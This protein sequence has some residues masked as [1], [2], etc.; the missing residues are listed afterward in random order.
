MASPAVQTRSTTTANAATITVTLPASSADGDLIFIFLCA[1]TVSTTWSLNAGSSGWTELFDDN[2]EAGYYKQIGA[3]EANPVFDPSVTERTGASALRITGHENPATQVPEVSASPNTGTS[4]APDPSSVTPTGGSK[5]YLFIACAGHDDARSGFSA[6][7]TNYSN[8]NAFATGGGANGCTGAT[9]ERA[10]TASTDDPDAFATGRSEPWAARTVVIHPVG[11]ATP[12]TVSVG[13]TVVM[14]DNLG[15]GSGHSLTDDINFSDA[16]ALLFE[17]LKTLADAVVLGDKV[18]LGTGHVLNDQMSLADAIEFSFAAF[19]EAV[20]NDDLNNWAD[21]TKLLFTFDTSSTDSLILS[22]NVEKLF[23]YLQ[24][25]N[26]EINLLDATS[27]LYT[28]LVSKGD[29]LSISDA[30]EVLRGYFKSTGDDLN[31]WQDDTARILLAFIEAGPA[32]DLN[33]WQ[34]AIE[35]AALAFAGRTSGDDLNAWAEFIALRY[36]YRIPKGEQFSIADSLS[37]LLTHHLKAQE[38]MTLTDV[39]ELLYTYLLTVSDQMTISDA[40]SNLLTYLLNVGDNLAN[41]QDAVNTSLISGPLALSRAAADSINWAEIVSLALDWRLSLQ[42][43][44]SMSDALSVVLAGAV[45]GNNNLSNDNLNLWDD[46]L[47]IGITG[48]YNLVLGNNVK[49]LFAETRGVIV[50]AEERRKRPI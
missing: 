1:N 21:Q 18:N 26:D 35:T 38:Q 20:A 19:L 7:P 13:D 10:L 25:S 42:D 39:I 30:I 3:S 27:K 4:T 5:D 14:G 44:M 23:T 34:D 37:L 28:Y 16:F 15:G 41:W 8:L 2:G 48:A 36:N 33:S 45:V 12:L 29:V 22:D 6:A 32:D 43:V 17:Y 47:S 24:T 9:A 31:S 11:T 49:R 46:R 50:S 40:I